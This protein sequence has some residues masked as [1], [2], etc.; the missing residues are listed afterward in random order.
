[1]VARH[2]LG[3]AASHYGEGLYELDHFPDL[4]RAGSTRTTQC[5]GEAFFWYLLT[6]TLGIGRA[7]AILSGI[8]SSTRSRYESG[9][10]HWE[11]FMT[12]QNK[13]H[14]ITRRGPNWDGNLIDF[15]MSESRIIGNSAP[16]P[17]AGRCPQ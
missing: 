17:F 5:S 2:A 3:A 8:A 10:K 14:W 16:P 7:N 12:A 4:G 11:M 9:W 15:T 1:M 13:P 6:R